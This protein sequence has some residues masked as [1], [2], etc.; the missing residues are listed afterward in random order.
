M[1]RHIVVANIMNSKM[2]L[3]IPVKDHML[4]LMAYFVEAKDDGASL[5]P[6][7]QS[8]M[9]FSSLWKDFGFR[10]TYNLWEKELVLTQLMKQL[11]TCELMLNGGK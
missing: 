10:A 5:E 9:V 6:K 2:K 7:T 11:L 4:K 3:G 1:A 8:D